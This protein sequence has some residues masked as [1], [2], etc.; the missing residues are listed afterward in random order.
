MKPVETFDEHC[1]SSLYSSK[2]PLLDQRSE[3]IQRFGTV[4]VLDNSLYGHLNV[5]TKHAY[6][7]TSQ[8]RRTRTIETVDV[9]ERS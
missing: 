6:K 7:R 9:M 2:Y 3:D 4:A 1:V 8:T 5:Q